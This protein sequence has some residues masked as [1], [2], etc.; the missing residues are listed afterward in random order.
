[1]NFLTLNI[2]NVSPLS[3]YNASTPALRP[4]GSRVPSRLQKINQHEKN[5]YDP[6]IG[7]SGRLV[8]PR[9]QVDERMLYS[10]Q[11]FR[12]SR[13]YIIQIGQETVGERTQKL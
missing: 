2:N 11:S 6:A 3:R 10:R 8:C 13:Q 7:N 4:V 5:F 1:M 12:K 9:Q